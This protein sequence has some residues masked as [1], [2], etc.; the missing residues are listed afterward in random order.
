MRCSVLQGVAML[1]CA[2]TILKQL[3]GLS[4]LSLSLYVYIY[5]HICKSSERKREM[6]C[7]S[8]CVAVCCR[9]FLYVLQCVAVCCSVWD[10]MCAWESLKWS[11][12]MLLCVAAC[13]RAWPCC[14]AREMVL[15]LGT[16]SHNRLSTRLR[17][18]SRKHLVIYRYSFLFECTRI[19]MS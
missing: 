12:D 10:G 9:A 18:R 8:L 19:C 7:V 3:F 1:Q 13:C 14:S 15:V 4:I 5:T 2:A 16:V 11:E 6:A 17:L